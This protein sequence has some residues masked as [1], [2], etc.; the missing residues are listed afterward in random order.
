MMLSG[1]EYN[2]KNNLIKIRE[3]K[4]LD[5]SESIGNLSR[6][7]NLSSLI[8]RIILTISLRFKLRYSEE[9]KIR[10]GTYILSNSNYLILKHFF[11]IRAKERGFTSP[12]IGK[13][14]NMTR[15]SINYII[16]NC[17]NKKIS[18][19]LIKIAEDNK[20]E[21]NRSK[22]LRCKNCNWKG[23]PLDLL[24]YSNNIELMFCNNLCPL[25]AHDSLEEEFIGTKDEINLDEILNEFKYRKN[26]KGKIRR[27][28]NVQK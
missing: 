1:K 15:V 21:T 24:I 2:R 22:I 5:N 20:K 10:L 12:E 8:V 26:N 14:L 17:K 9:H 16:R 25:C 27:K 7:L 11:I 23:T 4:L 19:N 3:L 13:I 28:K 18:E 6:I